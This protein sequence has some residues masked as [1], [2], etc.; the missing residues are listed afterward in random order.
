MTERKREEIEKK[1]I[2]TSD[3]ELPLAGESTRQLLLDILYTASM[4]GAVFALRDFM[5]RIFQA[6]VPSGSNFILVSG[7]EVIL[8]VALT[9]VIGKRF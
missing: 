1:S 4:L 2:P 3:V 7:L 5:G 8:F 6:F 9:L